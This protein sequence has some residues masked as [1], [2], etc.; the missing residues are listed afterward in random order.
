V[1]VN[2]I[3]SRPAGEQEPALILITTACLVPGDDVDLLLRAHGLRTRHAPLCGARSPAELA[4]IPD[5]ATAAI[6]GNEP[7]TA[8]V[9]AQHP[10]LRAIVRTG[11]GYDSI[12]LDAATR[13]G[14]S[15]SNLPGINAVA[16]AEYTL[17]LI[18]SAA[19]HLTANAA[20]RGGAWPRRDGR[21]V[22]NSTLGVVGYGA[23]RREVATLAHGFRMHVLCA[24]SRP[25]AQ[26]V[27]GVTFVDLPTLLAQSDYVS[28]HAALTPVTRR[29]INERTLNLMKP[30]AV[31]INTARGGLVD[32]AALVAAVQR[33]TLAGAELDVVDVEPLPQDSPLRAVRGVHVY[34]HMA[35]QSEQARH[36][37]GLQAA[38][39]VI[40]T[41]D[42]RPRTSLNSQPPKF[43]RR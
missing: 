30:G 5:G 31:V 37:V 34:P 32:E 22:R 6:V 35:G 42:G 16:V 21:E 39:E 11:V 15:V 36:D 38:H 1:V 20:V 10:H 9:L 8:A 27:D 26:P 3:P 40:E 17:G 2:Q 43:G 14:I 28:L 7:L 12:D 4:E 33:G 19:R 41:L 29:M 24:T 23:T 13:L 25:P 18:L